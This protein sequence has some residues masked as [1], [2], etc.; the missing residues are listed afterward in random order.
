[1]GNVITKDIKN[2]YV[3]SGNRLV[4]G[5]GIENL[6]VFETNDAI[7]ISD[8]KYDQ[9]VKKIVNKLLEDNRSEGKTHRK[10][11]RPWGITLQLWKVRDGR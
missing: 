11:Y 8:K 1:M 6:L 2:C 7:L 3:R 9:D 4:A 5:L 10:V